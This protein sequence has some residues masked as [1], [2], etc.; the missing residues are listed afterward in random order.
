MNRI[1]NFIKL[2]FLALAL[3]LVLAVPIIGFVSA[4]VNW[5]GTCYGL[6]NIEREC[7]WWQF[8]W[9][10]MFWTLMFFI[11]FVFFTALAWIAMALVQ[12]VAHQWEKRKR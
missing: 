10:E 4:S 11:P 2:I 6:T 8:A 1:I 9:D 7:S 5:E 3:L 12:F